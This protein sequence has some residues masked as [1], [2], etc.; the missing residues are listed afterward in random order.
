MGKYIQVLWTG[1]HKRHYRLLHYST[2]TNMYMHKCSKENNPNCDYCGRTEDNLHLFTHCTRIKNIWKHYQTILTKLTGQSYTSQQHLFTIN[3]PN[4][5]KNTAKLTTTIIIQIILF[6]IWQSRNNYKYEHKLLP[7]Q[8]I[9]KI[10]AQLN[11]ILQIQYK[12]HKLQDTLDTFR[13]HFC[14]NEALAKIHNN[15]LTVIL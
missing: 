8:T 5:N 7:Q 11:N 2:K 14:I 15:I 9:D 4:T 3:I 12:K 1:I 6:E 10:N 13:G